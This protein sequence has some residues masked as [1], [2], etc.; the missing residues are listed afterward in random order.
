MS[1]AAHI[2]GPGFRRPTLSAY[3]ERADVIDTG[4]D[5]FVHRQIGRIRARQG[6]MRSRR[7]RRILGASAAHTSR[8]KVASDADLKAYAAEMRAG[9]SALQTERGL[10]LRPAGEALALIREV[11]DR[12]L[13]LRPY[14][15]QIMAA[16]AMLG[17]LLAEMRT[18]EGKTLSAAVAASA[19][20][21][22]GEPVH[23]ITVNDYLAR[24]DADTMRPLFD[25]LGLSV[26][27]IEEGQPPPLRRELYRADI[28][29]SSNKEIAF[30]YLRDRAILRRRPGNL[31]RKAE[32]L[33]E[34]R[35]DVLT[36]RGLHFAIVDEADSV[37][38]DEART[39]LIISGGDAT[40]GVDTDLF[41]KAMDAAKALK[42]DVDYRVM[43]DEH[44]IDVLEEGL[45]TLD[46]M[47]EDE[48]GAISVPVIRDHAV[49]QAL[50]ALH[51]FHRDIHYI[52]RDD[53][54]MIVDEFTGRVQ[55]DRTWSEGL[56]QMIELKEELEP[57]PPR[58]TVSRMTY[59]RYFRRYRRLAGMTGTARDA[60]AEF[61]SV[62]RLPV[63]RI[64]TNKPDVRSFA[65]DRVFRT[66]AAK[67]RAIGQRVAELHAKQ[68]PVLI[69]T[70]SVAASEE[71]AAKL[72]ERG[73]PHQVLSAR[74]DSFE[75]EIISKAGEAGGITIATNMAGRGTDIKLAD[76]VAETGGLHVIL[77]ER[78]DS[79][80]I[81][82]QLEG[83]CGRQG[84]PGRCEAFLS[85]EDELMRG[86]GAVFLR[87]CARIA[88]FAG[89]R[90][91]GVFLRLRQK[92]VERI[93]A[94][95]R[96][97]LLDVDR[98]LGDLL[99]FSGDIE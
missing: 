57:T 49:Q 93:H 37:L 90:A 34:A 38:I 99:A 98:N 29:Y 88:S 15:V 73:I 30:D 21:L 31:A 19:A 86:E 43:P 75:A 65:P 96:A 1:E 44:R 24:R 63:V 2:L 92:R 16:W 14:P 25:F 27:V 81:D 53:K 52:L 61:W 28:V 60:A 87:R 95:M 48:E 91:A 46:D 56:H 97:D 26:A 39:P 71:A 6:G 47:T 79:R 59:Q 51:L 94:R 7:L 4:F 77:T 10:P 69:G 89:P 3:F 74:Q 66:E 76:G 5:R 50:T 58:D 83:R 8:F 82:R 20:A 70:R 45:D 80:R 67:W 78:H 64:P 18:G 55:P 68:V 17:G 85:L 36:L 84:D 54:V 9:L 35:G 23:V 11:A 32:R 40:H 42:R 33:G 41:T 62:Y 22:G 13:G 12:S 72:S